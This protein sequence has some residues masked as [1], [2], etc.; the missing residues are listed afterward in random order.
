MR[1]LERIWAWVNL[2]YFV[3]FAGSTVILFYLMMF[4]IILQSLKR[5]V[6]FQ[7]RYALQKKKSKW[8]Y[9]GICANIWSKHIILINWVF[10]QSE[11]HAKKF[12]LKAVLPLSD[13]LMSIWWNPDSKS[14]IGNTFE[15]LR[16]CTATSGVGY[17]SVIV[18]ACSLWKS[19]TILRLGF[20]CSSVPFFFL[21]IVQI[22]DCKDFY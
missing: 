10:F 11:S 19:T 9:I 18:W 20:P 14:K 6:I 5:N 15:L 12:I 2:L 8:E 21:A 7:T 3:F 1:Y 17:L 16:F 22:G 13:S 4:P